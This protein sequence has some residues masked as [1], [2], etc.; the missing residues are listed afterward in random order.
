MVSTFIIMGM[1]KSGTTLISEMLDLSGI[2]MQEELDKRSYDQGNY[3]ER[4]STKA[5]NKKLLSSDGKNSL[6]VIRQLQGNQNKNELN[7]KAQRI[8]NDAARTSAGD[9]GFKDPRN[10]L[11]YDFWSSLLPEHK[12]ICIY[13]NPENVHAHYTGRRKLSVSRGFRALRAWSIYNNSMLKAYKSQSAEGRI[14]IN[15][16]RLMA[17]NNELRRLER[18][19]GRSLVD[20]RKKSMQRH[21]ITRNSRV[22]TEGKL[23][24]FLCGLEPTQIKDQLDQAFEDEARLSQRTTADD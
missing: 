18:F 12:I 20:R 10:C 7:L 16:E 14:M 19:V 15:Y 3:F 22:D 13:R 24:H 11:T 17:S 2:S 23:V 4:R 8:L 5:M 21:F 9:W 1:H 6:R